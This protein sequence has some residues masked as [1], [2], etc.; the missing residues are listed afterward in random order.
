MK[1]RDI[2]ALSFMAIMRQIAIA[3]VMY[4][5]ACDTY[6]ICRDKEV[7]KLRDMSL[8]YV[9]L[10]ST[11]MTNSGDRVTMQAAITSCIERITEEAWETVMK[12]TT[13]VLRNHDVQQPE[14]GAQ[15]F[16]LHALASGSGAALDT[17]SIL[18]RS[19]PKLSSTL[20][21]LRPIAI[22]QKSAK[23]K[24]QMLEGRTPA[25]E[26]E[27]LLITQSMVAYTNL[28]LSED[29]ITRAI[30]EAQEMLKEE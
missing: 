11:Y 4:R 19:S 27:L 26:K 3:D 13:F 22:E 17:V 24:F 25:T 5:L 15:I 16:A 10:M 1:Q 8:K 6:E 7:E 30:Q 9:R 18:L 23:L 2:K 28:L 20:K 21:S 14:A 29:T 12:A